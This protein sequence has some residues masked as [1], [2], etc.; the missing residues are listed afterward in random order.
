MQNSN[1]NLNVILIADIV[2]DPGIKALS[3]SIDTVIEK[4]KPQLIIANGENSA[5]GKGLT[6]KIAYQFFE[7]GIN[8]ITSGNHIWNKKKI[9]PLLDTNPY[10]LRPL[11]YPPNV[12]GHGSCI[13]E[14]SSNQ[15]IAIINLQGRT[16]MHSIDCP[17]RSIDKEIEKIH[18]KE[19]NSIIIDFHAEAT[20]EK[21][22]MGWYLDGRVSA[23]IGTH[24]HVQTAD[25]R[26][27]PAGTAYITDIGM[28]GSTNSVIGMDKDVALNRFIKQ[29]PFYYK[30]GDEGELKFCGVFVS[31]NPD[32]SQAECIERFRL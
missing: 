20:A 7:L 13:Y 10:I 30:I 27:L 28:T 24:T 11:N 22:A 17:F 5:S 25:E 23:V 3:R 26:I 16:F 14:I 29:I 8:V 1:S 19:I 21:I 4:Y 6:E 2:G 32:T 31:I 18:K 9:F 15:K 12:P